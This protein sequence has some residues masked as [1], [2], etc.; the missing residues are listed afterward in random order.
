MNQVRDTASNL[1][2]LV[3]ELCAQ[4]RASDELSLQDQPIRDLDVLHRI[5]RLRLRLGFHTLSA[6]RL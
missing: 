5:P 1:T 4:N 2:Q 3:D 6:S